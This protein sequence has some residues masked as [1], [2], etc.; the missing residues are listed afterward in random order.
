MPV[1][2]TLGSLQAS[3]THPPGLVLPQTQPIPD[4]KH[5]PAKQCQFQG[6]VLFFPMPPARPRLLR[7]LS[8]RSC[9]LS[10]GRHHHSSFGITFPAPPAQSSFGY[11]GR[12]PAGLPES[13]S[14]RNFRNYKALR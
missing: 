3:E 5:S 13:P 10:I 8:S 1:V 7:E 11:G 4:S 2:P 6:L 14:S 12:A 9:L